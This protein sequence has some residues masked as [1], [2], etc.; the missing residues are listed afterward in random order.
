MTPPCDRPLIG[1]AGDMVI[2]KGIVIFPVTIG[3]V[4]YRVVHMIDFLIFDHHSAYNIILGRPFLTIFKMV[5]FKNYLAMNIPIAGEII[6][7]KGD[8]QLAQGCYFVASKASYQIATN[9]FLEGYPIS[10]RPFTSLSKRALAR[11]R[12]AARKKAQRSTN[13]Q[14][15]QAPQ[16]AGPMEIDVIASRAP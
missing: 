5:I 1:F 13:S 12:R 16:E 15:P 8:Q 4:P 3:K 10:T 14:V 7:I 11:R 9:M 2:P 6:T